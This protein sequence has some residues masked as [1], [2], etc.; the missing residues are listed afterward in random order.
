MVVRWYLTWLDHDANSPL[1]ICYFLDVLYL[2]PMCQC[3]KYTGVC[4]TAVSEAFGVQHR[5]WPSWGEREKGGRG[6]RGK[7]GKEEREG[8]RKREE[9]EEGEGI[10]PRETAQES[11]L[12]GKVW[13][14]HCGASA[15][16]AQL[17]TL[18]H[19]PGWPLRTTKC[20]ENWFCEEIIGW[21]WVLIPERPLLLGELTFNTQASVLKTSERAHANTASISLESSHAWSSSG[22]L[23]DLLSCQIGS[24]VSSPQCSW[25]WPWCL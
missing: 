23:L 17:S 24:E 12:T 8:G 22:E 11:M 9:G 21:L 13:D 25:P 20:I 7:G 10:R 1:V 2:F 14:Q 16:W 18:S 19:P 5:G 6:G 15:L 4:F 3:L